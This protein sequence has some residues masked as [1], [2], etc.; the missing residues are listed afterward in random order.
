MSRGTNMWL[1]FEKGWGYIENIWE[2]K[3]LTTF[4]IWQKLQ[5]HIFNKL[6]ERQA[7]EMG[8]KPQWEKYNN[9][10]AENQW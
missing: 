1:D 9:Q 6:S 4:Q 7:K 3:I 8:R 10:L 5:T 2:K